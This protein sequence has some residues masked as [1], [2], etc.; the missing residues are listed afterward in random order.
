MPPAGY[1]KKKPDWA[2]K[3]KGISS[4][5]KAAKY[6]KANYGVSKVD[7]KAMMRLAKQMAE[8]EVNKNI[9]T[10]YSMAMVRMIADD[11]ITASTGWALKGLNY[12]AP[13]AGQPRKLALNNA[14]I[15][16]LGYLSQVGSSTLPGYRQG[17]RTYSGGLGASI[18]STISGGSSSRRKCCCWWAMEK[19]TPPSSCCV[20]MS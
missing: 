1:K 14:L 13:E 18:S 7:E 9:E 10:Q 11:A 8:R 4:V 20:A 3:P 12:R 2:G 6:T 5:A 15:F 16:N 19:G 17:Q